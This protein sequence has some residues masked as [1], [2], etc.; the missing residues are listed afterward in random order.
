MRCG[1]AIQPQV[2][3][4]AAPDRQHN[5]IH[6]GCIQVYHIFLTQYIGVVWLCNPTTSLWDYNTW[7]TA[8]CEATG[9]SLIANLVSNPAYQRIV[10]LELMKAYT[11]VKFMERS[12][13]AVALFNWQVLDKLTWHAPMIM[14]ILSGIVKKPAQSSPLICALASRVM[15]RWSN[16]NSLLQRLSLW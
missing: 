2:Y 8:Q 4:I 13:K 12:P 14:S 9:T 15:K 6:L 11:S 5:V 7:Q 16:N 1:Y 10:V 3:E